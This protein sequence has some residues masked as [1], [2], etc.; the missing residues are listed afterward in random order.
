M[1]FR[2]KCVFGIL[3]RDCLHFR[4][5]CGN[6]QSCQL[7]TATSKEARPRWINGVQSPMPSTSTP[8]TLNPATKLPESFVTL[9][10]DVNT[11]IYLSQ[12]QVY[13]CFSVKSHSDSWCPTT[14]QRTRS[15]ELNLKTR[16]SKIENAFHPDT[17]DA[18]YPACCSWVADMKAVFRLRATSW[19]WATLLPSPFRGQVMRR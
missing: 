3:V 15:G 2:P 4:C 6:C 14:C 9:S 1:V 16:E 17:P 10:L 18:P 19:S 5:R 8:F 12:N 11:T 7:V 13:S